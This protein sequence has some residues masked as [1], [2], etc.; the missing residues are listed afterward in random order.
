MKYVNQT[1]VV[2]EGEIIRRAFSSDIVKAIDKENRVVDFVI[3]T[4]TVDRYGDIIRVGGWDLKQYKKNPVVLF[5][6][7]S[8]IPPI[9]K[10]LSVNKDAKSL[11]ATA[12]FMDK[13]VSAFAHSIFRMLEE[14]FLRAVSV[15]FIPKDWEKINDDDG[16]LTG[17]EFKK[18][19]L[20]EFSVVPIPANPDCLM[21]AKAK[22]IDVSPFKHFAENILD[23]WDDAGDVIKSLYGSNRKDIEKI[24]KNSGSSMYVVP[25]H[26]QDELL[27][28]NL[29][30]V[31]KQK[32]EK[33][34]ELPPSMLVE[35]EHGSSEEASFKELA[36]KNNY[37]HFCFYDGHSKNKGDVF[38]YVFVK[39]AESDPDHEDI[40]IDQETINGK[41]SLHFL[42]I[43]ETVALS[44]A[45]LRMF[46]D[47]E[48]GEIKGTEDGVLVTLRSADVDL[49]YRI[50]SG[51][52]IMQVFYGELVEKMVKDQDTVV[53]D[54]GNVSDAVDNKSEDEDVTETECVVVVDETKAEETSEETEEDK[55]KAEDEEDEDD[56]DTSDDNPDDENEDEDE[57]KSKAEDDEDVD[58][59]EEDK[60]VEAETADFDFDGEIKNFEET[61]AS[62]EEVLDKGLEEGHSVSK[63]TQRK[64]T[65]LAGYMRDLAERINPTAKGEQTEDETKS[66][67][68]DKKERKIKLGE[69][70]KYLETTIPNILTPIFEKHL[71]K[72]SGKLD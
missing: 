50:V 7:N 9:G 58:E 62:F 20:L 1:P 25:S 44:E 24:R 19:E 41:V 6:H 52:E 54:T 72:L 48:H 70:D 56:E 16:H 49:V 36:A 15:G 66:T 64:L 51:N 30:A 35:C 23:N 21:D 14:K 67:V 65:F 38:K 12:Q 55:A 2:K 40:Y 18:Q 37:M 4:E 69:V 5:G 10:A 3:S 39:R 31:K 46:G 11:K 61:L 13:E 47:N 68:S 34:K 28:K 8:H 45:F 32:E 22:G 33:Q 53:D 17:F 71:K 63:H 26:V 59:D 43:P 42:N 57:D 27:R 60:D 29:E